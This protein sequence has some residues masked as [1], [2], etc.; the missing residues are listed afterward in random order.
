MLQLIATGYGLYALITG[1]LPISINRTVVGVPARIA[2]AIL[3][4]TLPLAL[5]IGFIIGLFVGFDILP[6]EVLDYIGY[7]DLCLA[8]VVPAI[9]LTVGVTMSNNT[10]PEVIDG[11][12][13]EEVIDGEIIEE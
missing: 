6:S 9:G 11:E 1:K 5:V 12:I 8:C 3:A 4:A 7:V 10:S 2:G 13:V